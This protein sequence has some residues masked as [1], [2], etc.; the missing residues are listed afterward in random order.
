MRLIQ[1]IYIEYFLL[2]QPLQ[3]ILITIQVLGGHVLTNDQ[4][5][6]R[7]CLLNQKRSQPD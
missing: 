1:N 4:R 7:G 6:L 3:P 2:C 5:I